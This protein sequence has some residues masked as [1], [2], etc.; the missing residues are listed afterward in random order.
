MLSRKTVI[1]LISV[2]AAFLII[3]CGGGGGGGNVGQGGPDISPDNI[4]GTNTAGTTTGGTTGGTTSD[5]SS[6]SSNIADSTTNTDLTGTTST[7][8]GVVV[9]PEVNTTI[10]G[11]IDTGKDTGT[12]TA[13]GTTDES[14]VDTNNSVT[15]T[16]DTTTVTEDIAVVLTGS[17]DTTGTAG[18]DNGSGTTTSD[19][20]SSTVSGGS[21]SS[22]TTENATTDTGSS[23]VSGGSSTTENTGSSTGGSAV[24]EG[25]GSSTETTTG[26]TTSEGTATTGTTTGGSTSGSTGVS[27]S[28]DTS[29]DVAVVS[30]TSDSGAGSTVDDLENDENV[31]QG[32]LVYT[33]D[34]SLGKWYEVAEK[35]LLSAAATNANKAEIAKLRKEITDLADQYKNGKVKHDDALARLK[36]IRKKIADLRSTIG[37]GG[38]TQDGIM[39]YWANQ[40]L[41][42]NIK[43]GQPGWYRL[44]IVAKNIG[45][46]P[47]DYDRFC[48][49]V[50]NGSDT[51]AGISVKASDNAYFRGSAIIKLD[52]MAGTQL[53]ILWTN[54]AYLQNKYDAN[55]NIK[56][57]ALIKI[58]EP[59]QKLRSIKKFKGDQYSF[60]DGRWF[61]DK[62]EAYT[63]WA[64]Q[65]IGYTFK[66]MEEGQYE[67][68]I[69]AE[70]HGTLPLPKNYKEFNVDV[71]S[72][73][74]SAT[75]AIPAKDN[76]VS[77]E[78]FTINFPEGDTTLYLTWTNDEYKEN[79][80]D[81]NFTIKSIQVKKVKQSNLTAYLLKTKPG[82]RVFILSAFLMISAV[83]LGI[84]MKNRKSEADT[85]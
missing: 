41:Y 63:F 76:G 73:Y 12:T 47:D 15:N 82:N 45:V 18:T 17:T 75:V 48:F 59:S 84:Y 23:T 52:K 46:L 34:S 61:F 83:L 70:N 49:N 43:S 13:A 80:Y 26:G 2:F 5:V 58:K 66:N 25:T 56:K 16:T 77:K 24:T 28:T 74:D 78:T 42:L 72:E 11:T 4:S 65:V 50:N 8:E 6:T 33:I 10:E 31:D 57:I 19:S 51:I 21:G 44:V 7:T 85:L 40:N 27:G 54:D 1:A 29:T 32:N 39:T 35:E 38:R 81:T 22:T 68:T 9:E 67:V 36:A 14:G 55:V 64:D 62:N 79:S 71:D 60:T 37:N 30:G 69:E 20:G 53:N 3:S